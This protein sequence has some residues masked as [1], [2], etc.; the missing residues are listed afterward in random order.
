MSSA[1]PRTKKFP[2]AKQRR[3]DQLLEKNAEGTISAKEKTALELLVAEAEALM[4]ANSQQLAEF[5]R[6][7]SPQP[8]PSAVPVTV[9]VNPQLTE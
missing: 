1:M 8:P 2:A 6:N 3:L 7:Q 9:W 5:A 4:V